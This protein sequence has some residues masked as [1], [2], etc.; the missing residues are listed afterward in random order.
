MKQRF[1]KAIYICAGSSRLMQ[2]LGIEKLDFVAQH[3]LGRDNL[4]ASIKWR[5]YHTKTVAH[6]VTRIMLWKRMGAFGNFSGRAKIHKVVRTR[7]VKAHVDLPVTQI[8]MWQA[9]VCI[10][11]E[12]LNYLR[13]NEIKRASCIAPPCDSDM[14]C[15]PTL[16]TVAHW[17][18]CLVKPRLKPQR[19]NGKSGLLCLKQK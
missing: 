9:G 17:R 7:C 2:A 11:L 13:M 3:F 8:S 6:A 12:T 19:A 18:P 1:Q 10:V 4:L 5:C 16:A 14:H 15:S